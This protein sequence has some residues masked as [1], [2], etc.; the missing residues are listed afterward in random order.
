MQLYVGGEKLDRS[1]ASRIAI[2]IRPLANPLTGVQRYRA[3][4]H[5]P[6]ITDQYGGR[7][8]GLR[9][10]G[11]EE[12]GIQNLASRREYGSCAN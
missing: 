5:G 12:F 7:G 6:L 3:K 4:G 10:T 11:G 8:Y 9:V 2:N 1:K